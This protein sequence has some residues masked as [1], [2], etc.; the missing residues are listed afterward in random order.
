VQAEMQ[1]R[2]SHMMRQMLFGVGVFLVSS[3]MVW[4]GN[5][6]DIGQ[7]MGTV[8]P[9]AR[10]LSLSPTWHVY[11]FKKQGIA[12]LQVND[13]AGQVHVGLG[14]ANG[15]YVVLPM[16]VDAG[17][18]STPDAPLNIT[19]SN[20]EV[21]YRDSETVLSV[22]TNSAGQLVWSATPA[23]SNTTASPNEACDPNDCGINR[24]ATSIPTSGVA[25]NATQASPALCD[26][27]DCG[28]NRVVKQV[29][30]TQTSVTTQATNLACDPSDCGI[31]RQP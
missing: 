18:V 6:T 22:G 1:Q 11:T 10:D 7:G 23:T 19:L 21:V 2:E 4:A 12:Y 20:V 14:L 30:T 26:T 9:N 17:S 16:G 29:S 31:N 24:V 5:S 13:N 3:S 27:N 28:I 25:S 15:V 8:Q